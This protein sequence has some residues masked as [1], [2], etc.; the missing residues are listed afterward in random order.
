MPK[1]I[2]Y[3]K[4]ILDCIYQGKMVGSVE[5]TTNEGGIRMS[6]LHYKDTVEKMADRLQK[7]FKK[8]EEK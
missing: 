6:I 5:F 1:S 4:V 3:A 2:D 8:E 7:L